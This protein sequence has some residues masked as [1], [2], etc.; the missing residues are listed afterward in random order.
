[1]DPSDFKPNYPGL[2]KKSPEGAWAFVPDPLPPKLEAT[3]DL[4][5]PLSA[6]DRALSELAGV[7]GNLP[8]PHLLINPFMRR[9]AVLSSRIEGTQSSFGELLA[10][11]AAGNVPPAGSADVS[12]IVNYV[13]ALEH[14]LAQLEKLPVSLR[15]IKEV[16]A[17][18]M[19]GVRGE[20]KTPGEFRRQQNW[21]GGTDPKTA[22]FVPPPVTDM[23]AALDAL[24]RYLHDDPLNLPPLLRLA[25]AHYQFEA[26]HPFL[27][28][29]GRIG[30]LLITLTLCAEKILPAPLLYLSAFFEREKKTYAD[31]M[32]RV[33]QEGVWDEWLRFFLRGVT[34]Q[35]K[36]GVQRSKRVLELRETYRKKLQ[37]ERASGNVLSLLDQLVYTPMTTARGAS[38]QLDVTYQGAQIII[39]KLVEAGILEEVPDTR[40]RAYVAREVVRIFGD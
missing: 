10:F 37:A 24:E 2:L 3:W 13:R 30:R 5:G 23:H 17:V 6:A 12:E 40:P 28:G 29:N 14:G 26:I 22:R 39:D 16:H 19:K 34:E 38:E 31:L 11:E 33:S 20:N 32:L 15:L 18:L 21:I 8:N 35:S 9:E 25:L 1:M 7:A 36:D 27:D 4:Y